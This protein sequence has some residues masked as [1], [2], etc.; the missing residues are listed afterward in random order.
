MPNYPDQVYV[1]ICIK[2][3]ANGMAICTDL[4]MWQIALVSLQ[5]I[6]SA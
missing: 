3:R 5:G 1:S 6:I 2:K 4:A